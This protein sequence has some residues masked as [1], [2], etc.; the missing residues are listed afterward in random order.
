MEV[1]MPHVPEISKDTIH[2]LTISMTHDRDWFKKY[3]KDLKKDNTLVYGLLRVALSTWENHESAQGYA[4]GICT[5]Y[6]LIKNQ[7]EANELND[8]YNNDDGNELEK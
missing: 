3:L 7:I 2:S 5:M 4:K 6:A 1:S 8:L